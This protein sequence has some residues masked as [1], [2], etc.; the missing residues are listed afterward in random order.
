[1]SNICNFLDTGLTKHKL[2]KG[3]LIIFCHLFKRVIPESFCML[4]IIG[5]KENVISAVTV[6]SRIVHPNIVAEI[7]KD[8]SK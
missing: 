5:I 7:G 3:R 4:I 1:M 6:A 2:E 8:V